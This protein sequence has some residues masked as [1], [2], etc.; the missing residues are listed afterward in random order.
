MNLPIV[1]TDRGGDYKPAKK[2]IPIPQADPLP[3]ITEATSDQL[4]SIAM[5]A[6]AVNYPAY[7]ES[8]KELHRRGEFSKLEAER[9]LYRNN[10]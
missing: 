10:Y 5:Q 6:K 2:R 4:I 8:V 9:R 7:V 1:Y 3:S